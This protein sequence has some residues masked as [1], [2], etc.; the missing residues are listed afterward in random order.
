MRPILPDEIARRFPSEVLHIIYSFVPHLPKE[1]QT[2][3][4]LQRELKKIQSLK[5]K[6]KTGTYMRDLDDFILER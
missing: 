5:L 1:K 6:G 4:S 2:S 3:P